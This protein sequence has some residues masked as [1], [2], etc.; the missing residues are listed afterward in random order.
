M[1]PDNP[2][3]GIPEDAARIIRMEVDPDLR[4]QDAIAW[5]ARREAAE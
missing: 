2:L 3:D 1:N 4:R 5:W